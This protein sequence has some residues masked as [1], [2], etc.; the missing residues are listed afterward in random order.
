M[1]C[2]TFYTSIGAGVLVCRASCRIIGCHCWMRYINMDDIIVH[3]STTTY[4]Y[5]DHRSHIVNTFPWNGNTMEA[6]THRVTV[7][8]GYKKH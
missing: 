6:T 2:V 8:A 3:S 7:Y 1:R 5:V 4:A